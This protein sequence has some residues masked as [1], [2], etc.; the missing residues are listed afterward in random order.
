MLSSNK[1]QDPHDKNK[2]LKMAPIL[3]LDGGLG[4]SLEQKYK[5]KF[6]HS[7]PL[8]SSDLLVSDFATLQKCQSDFGDVPVDI[9]LTATYQVSIKG[10]AATKS[11]AFPEGVPTSEIPRFLDTAV[12]T[13]E[14]SIQTGA[15]VALSV[16]PYG[17]CMIPSQEYSGKYDSE[18]DD[19]EALFQWHS[20]RMALFAQ[21]PDVGRRLGFVSLETV[22]RVD[23]VV[24]MRRALAKES[25]LADVP[26]WISCLFP[27]DNG[28]LPDGT[29]A[30]DAVTA[31]LDPS[32]STAVP[33]GIGIN[34]TKVAKLD[35]ILQ[36]YEVA[37]A[38]LVNKGVISEWPAL[39]LY[40]D[41]TNG[42]VY[43]TTTQQ[44]EMQETK[45]DAPRVS[46]EQQLKEVVKATEERGKWKQTV[47]GGCCMARSEDIARLRAVLTG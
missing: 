7:T 30:A 19:A 47:V 24:A 3:I 44:W 1:R 39:A 28:C 41:G 26:F 32:L 37:V 18:H 40:P 43:N 45:S 15:Q 35:S 12:Q 5:L 22:P 34:C 14:S 9:L 10:F 17:A 38:Q 23:E 21:V 2:H 33:W 11:A 25:D 31:M 16:G 6:T 4:T 20:E 27:G 46:W 29:S 13:A 8:W 42:E 36:Q